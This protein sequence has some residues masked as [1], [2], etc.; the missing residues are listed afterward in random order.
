M[1]NKI[2]KLAIMIAIPLYTWFSGAPDGLSQEGWRLLGFYLS[3]IVG[4]MLK[5]YSVQIIFLAIIAA[6]SIFMDN[7]KI[8]LAGYGS[9]S[10]WMIIAAFSLSVAFG[11]TGLGHRLAYHLVSLF[12]SSVL[13]LG[14]VTALIDFILSPA[15][16]SNTARA[17]GIV[18]PINLSIAESIHSF[19]GETARK[20]G[21]YILMNGYF[22]TKIT[23]FIF[24]TAMAPNLLALDFVNKILGI[25][26]TW[27]EW[28]LAMIVPGLLMLIITP[29]I[30]YYV[31]RPT[32]T[33][34]DN[35]ALA[36]K[37][38]AELG[39]MK[40]SEKILCVIF[41][42]ALIGWALPSIGIAVNATAVALVAMA[43]TLLTKIITWNDI[44]ETKAVWNT[45]IWFGGLLGISTALS[46]AKFFDWLAIFMESHMAFDLSPLM[47]AVI[48]AVISCAIR[49][50]FASSTAYIASM[51]PV[52]LT[53]G[54][55]TGVDPAL[56]GLLML[57]TNAFGGS[58]THYGASPG[59]IIFSAGYN[60]VKT[61]W[62]VGA[63]LVIVYLIID[64]T[65]SPLWWSLTGYIG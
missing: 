57:T 45:F 30:A 14:Y 35:K 62:T 9:T 10:L 64:F 46:K 18:Y 37:G 41:V 53:V 43:F 60:T 21:S 4:L 36:A 22:V 34:I 63:L 15:T 5:P 6:S 32:V 44:V 47:V 38:L 2:W 48:L 54:K 39:D 1:N 61:W 59:P 13:R 49:Y 19:P 65:I 24:M 58:L 28:A 25:S 20:G 3:A 52:F 29:L 33:T 31:D 56:F 16:P 55:A 11:K 26:L 50:L 42:L 27:G 23:S 12:G 7:A 17:A 51:M 8:L 40:T